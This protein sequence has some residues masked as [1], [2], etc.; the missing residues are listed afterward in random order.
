DLIV[1][2]N[3]EGKQGRLDGVGFAAESTVAVLATIQVVGRKGDKP[4]FR[5]RSGKI[6]VGSVVGV[7][8]IARDAVPA[9]LTDNDGPALARP[10]VLGQHQHSPGEQI[11]EN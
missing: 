10:Q 1:L 3:D 6:V 9:M 4:A 5:K 8:R 2:G 11:G 7:E